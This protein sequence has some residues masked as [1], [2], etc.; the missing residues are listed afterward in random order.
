MR[1]EVVPFDQND[2]IARTGCVAGDAGAI[3]ATTHYE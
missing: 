3:D 1:G 2:S